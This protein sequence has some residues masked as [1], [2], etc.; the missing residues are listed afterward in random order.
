MLD[1]IPQEIQTMSEL[2]F[3]EFFNELLAYMVKQ[4]W[5]HLTDSLTVDYAQ[6]IEDAEDAENEIRKDLQE[7]EIKIMNFKNDLQALLNKL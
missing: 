4:K 5:N 1:K 2:E 7:T 6:Q 3:A